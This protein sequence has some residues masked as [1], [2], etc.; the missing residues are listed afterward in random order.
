MTHWLI[1]FVG[2]VIISAACSGNRPPDLRPKPKT[3]AIT[4]GDPV[5]K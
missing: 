1:A 4:V 2:L 5:P 3:V